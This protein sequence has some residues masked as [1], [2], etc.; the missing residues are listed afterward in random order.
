MRS[1]RKIEQQIQNE[2]LDHY[3]SLGLIVWRQ[4][5]GGVPMIAPNGR[6]YFVRLGDRGTPDIVGVLPG[7]RCFATEVKR[8]GK[9]PDEHQIRFMRQINYQGGAAF[10]TNNSDLAASIMSHLLTGSSI[11]LGLD[12]RQRIIPPLPSRR[13]SI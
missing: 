1:G 9:K 6:R 7:G 13:D 8:P 2:I 4:N 11:S 12:G 5:S 3:R 10:W